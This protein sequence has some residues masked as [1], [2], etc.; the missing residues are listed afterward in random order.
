MD[1]KIENLRVFNGVSFVAHSARVSGV[2]RVPCECGSREDCERCAGSGMREPTDEEIFS[3]IVENDYSSALEHVVFSFEIR[4]L[5]KGN[6]LELLEHRIASHTGRSTRY[7]SEEGFDFNLPPR[8]EEI[9]RKR[10]IDEQEYKALALSD[11]P[12]PE[13]LPKQERKILEEY[14]RAMRTSRE[15]YSALLEL[16]AGKESARYAT[17]FAMHTAY[18]YTINLRSLINFFGLRLCV[19]A[20]PE[21]RELAA[22]LY[23]AVREKF[24]QISL[25]W[26]RGYNYAACPENEVR[27]SPQGR[28]CPFKDR[29]SRVFIPTRKQIR[30][31]IALE[32]FDQ[33]AFEKVREKLLRRWAG[34]S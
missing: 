9:L 18:T 16:G 15:A 8:V 7:Q 6:A 22:K 32:K 4:G 5:S 27:D 21:M 14:A 26:C 11:A 2:G 3:M 31:G 30:E 29:N 1:I 20:S 23:M 33:Q 24:P 19:R 28:E 12:M 17:P 13:Q 25:V 34:K 10:G